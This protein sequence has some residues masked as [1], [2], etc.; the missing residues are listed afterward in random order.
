MI[1]G[2][3]LL[4]SIQASAP[5]PQNWAY[6][7][8]ITN[9]ARVYLAT[10]PSRAEYDQHLRSACGEERARLRRQV[11]ERHVRQG[12]SRTDAERGADEF[13]ATIRIQMLDLQPRQGERR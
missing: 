5:G 1:F 11:I 6:L 9:S 12:Q 3:A 7:T 2:I 13:F 10:R 4:L 8:C